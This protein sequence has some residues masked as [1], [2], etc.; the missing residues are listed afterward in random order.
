MHMCPVCGY[1]HLRRP[2]SDFQ[3][4]PSCG[5]E[6][7]YADATRT[8]DEL[9][10]QWLSNGSK[11]HSKRVAPPE[12]W[13]AYLQLTNLNKHVQTTNQIN[14]KSSPVK[15]VT[16]GKTQHR[17]QRG[18]TVFGNWQLIETGDRLRLAFA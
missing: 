10:Q 11:W 6:F 15:V 13:S 8:P 18:V 14:L 5:T 16:I 17:Q 2:A 7:S 12:H 9:R 3:I 1:D 4:C